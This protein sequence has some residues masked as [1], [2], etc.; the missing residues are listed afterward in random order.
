MPTFWVAPLLGRN[1][2]VRLE[3]KPPKQKE[4]VYIRL[5][6]MLGP[7]ICLVCYQTF[8]AALR[9]LEYDVVGWLVAPLVR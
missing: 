4:V 2:T 9:E 6:T 7:D 8:M 1:R 3:T 5:Q